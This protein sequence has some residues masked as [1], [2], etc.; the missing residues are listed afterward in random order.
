M[1]SGGSVG[2]VPTHPLDVKGKTPVNL[3]AGVFAV[4]TRGVSGRVTVEDAAKWKVENKPSR[5]LMQ[6]QLAEVA[7]PA[8][9][10]RTMV[11]GRG[12]VGSGTATGGR[13]SAIVYDRTERKFV[14]S[15]AAQSAERSAVEKSENT[16]AAQGQ[17]NA[18]GAGRVRISPEQNRNGNATVQTPAVPPARSVSPPRATLP[19]PSVPR[20]VTVQR[21][22]NEGGGSGRSGGGGS[23]SSRSSTGSSAGTSAPSSGSSA[24]SSS[25]GSS[26]GGGRP[27]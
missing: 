5:E 11:A 9:F 15:N 26:S 6:N 25:S 19:P 24:R 1:K 10:S 18:A 7:A 8:R 13:E 14:N 2:I 17:A 27:H 22:F 16:S 4:T 20:S 12:T 3:S 23:S 21:S